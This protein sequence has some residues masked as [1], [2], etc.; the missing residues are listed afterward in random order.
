MEMTTGEIQRSYRLSKN[1]NEQISI[2]ADLNETTEKE[3]RRMLKLEEG[4]KDV[5]RKIS[6]KTCSEQVSDGKSSVPV[7]SAGS[8]K[9]ESGVVRKNNKAGGTRTDKAK[10]SDKTRIQVPKSVIEFAYERLELIEQLIQEYEREYK[11]LAD[12]VLSA[13]VRN[14]ND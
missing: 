1:K 13:E 11:E 7:R 10:E 14:G 2:L 4:E 6:K 9:A 8:T 12:F 5:R 3:I